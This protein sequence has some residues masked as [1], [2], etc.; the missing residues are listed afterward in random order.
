M[1]RRRRV[2]KRSQWLAAM[3]AGVVAC[4]GLVI[5]SSLAGANLAGSNFE[6]TDANMVCCNAAGNHDWQNA[7][8]LHVGQDLPTGQT[9]NS[10]GQGTS[11]NDLNVT[12]VAGSIP[13]SKADLGLFADSTETLA[14]GDVMLYLAW[15]RNNDSA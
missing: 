13:N 12:V 11:E 4:L 7:P 8:H 14:N 10:F 15:T 3:T 5:S 9:D 2:T 1:I 6:S